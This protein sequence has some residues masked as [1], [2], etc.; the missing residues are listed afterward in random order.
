LEL[1]VVEHV[2][3]AIVQQLQAVRIAVEVGQQQQAE[4]H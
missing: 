3:E 2:V 1:V 4:V